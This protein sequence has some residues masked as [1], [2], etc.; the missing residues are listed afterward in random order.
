M[1]IELF[2]LSSIGNLLLRIGIR[3]DAVG[4][5]PGRTQIGFRLFA[6]AWGVEPGGWVGTGGGRKEI[7]LLIELPMV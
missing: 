4:A 2:I 7:A 6:R 1:V 3:G 5:R